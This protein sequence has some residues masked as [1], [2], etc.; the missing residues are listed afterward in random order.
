MAN[1]PTPTIFH[2]DLDAFFAS[3]EE[4]LNPNLKGRPVIVG[5]LP[6][7]RGV[8]AC[9][10]YEARKLGVRT[11]MPL[12]KAFRLAPRA[13]FLRGNFE[14]YEEF[15]RKFFDILCDFSPMVEPVS[16]D[17]AYVDVTGC[18]HL[19][20]WNNDPVV[21]A[22]AIKEAI[23][24]KLNLAASIGIASNKLCAKIASDLSKPDGLLVVPYGEE[25][26]FLAPLPVCVIPGIGRRTE[27]A[28]RALGIHTVGD[29]SHCD[30][31][32][33][34]QTF[35][36][37][38][39]YL[40]DAANGIDH[41]PVS[42]EMDATRS[43]SRGTTFAE[44]TN[45]R[46]FIDAVLFYLSEKVAMA[47]RDEGLLAGTV[48]VTLRYADFST[49]QKSHTF[50]YLTNSEFEIFDRARKLFTLLWSRR[51]QVRFIAVGVA[52]LESSYSQLE[53]F[54]DARTK[55]NLLIK[56]IDRIRAKFGYRAAYF[57]IVDPMQRTYHIHRRGFT[58]H[59]P[60]LSR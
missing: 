32:L 42:P 13:I 12:S 49:Y 38:S 16:L 37:V 53:L 20:N 8:V 45:D 30:P 51:M 43:I 21:M 60:S 40:H 57:G 19:G 3:V 23:N 29:L 33:L 17:E 56:S 28:L 39:R 46:T 34:R 22:R 2:I 59:T 36:I 24:R 41:R 55:R 48:F 27:E 4:A 31:L 35:G 54:M 44:D 1:S 25:K 11:A 50:D 26:N 10:N 52:S 6:D 7:E 47:L 58:L 18:L 9:P 5:G 15:S 14:N